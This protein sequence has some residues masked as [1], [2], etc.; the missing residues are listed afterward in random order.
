MMIDNNLTS[1]SN[2]TFFIHLGVPMYV[3]RMSLELFIMHFNGSHVN[4]S[5]LPYIPVIIQLMHSFEVDIKIRQPR[6]Q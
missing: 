3:D 5:T 1:K 6:E 2:L 4:V